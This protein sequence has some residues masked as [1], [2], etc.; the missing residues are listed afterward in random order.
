MDENGFAFVRAIRGAPD[1]DTAMLPVLVTITSPTRRKVI[2]ALLA[3]ADGV[4]SKPF[5]ARCLADQVR[6]A[7]LRLR[8]FVRTASYFGPLPSLPELHGRLG[9]GKTTPLVTGTP[10]PSSP[11]GAGVV[12]L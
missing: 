3:G 1:M 9:V 10:A 6:V 2:E 5:S 7:A 4:V 8:P 12:L 11:G